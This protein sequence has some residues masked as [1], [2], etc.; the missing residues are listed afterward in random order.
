MSTVTYG[1]ETWGMGM[2]ESH[3]LDFMEIKYLRSICAVTR[4]D[5]WKNEQVRCRVD[6][7]EKMSDSVDR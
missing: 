7:R 3:E 5:R 6:V 1:V 4:M 2:D